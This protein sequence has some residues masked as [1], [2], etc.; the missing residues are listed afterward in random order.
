MEEQGARCPNCQ[1]VF[2]V[3]ASQLNAAGGMVRCGICLETFDALSNRIDIEQQASPKSPVWAHI[4]DNDQVI[5]DRFD[6]SLLEEDDLDLSVLESEETAQGDPLESSKIESNDAYPPLPETRTVQ[7]ESK[8]L[9]EFQP[10]EPEP[11]FDWEASPEP[12]TDPDSASVDYRAAAYQEMEATNKAI[13][14]LEQTIFGADSPRENDSGTL[15]TEAGPA[16]TGP[17]SPESPEPEDAYQNNLLQRT[18]DATASPDAAETSLAQLDFELSSALPETIAPSASLEELLAANQNP[19][20]SVAMRSITSSFAVLLLGMGI[21][22]T[23]WFFFQADRLGSEADYASLYRAL[24][25]GLPCQSHEFRDIS[26]IQTKNLVVRTHPHFGSALRVDATLVNLAE[27]PQPFPRMVL[28]FEDLQGAVLARRSFKPEE[29]L[30]GELEGVGI[31]PSRQAI[32]F[33]LD[34][35]DPGEQAVSYTLI[36]AH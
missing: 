25:R 1:L 26:A 19:K 5:D 9:S 13:E 14:Q 7:P 36:P 29:Y 8:P 3:A 27:R 20:R 32:H 18:S 34:V 10:P 31:M 30:K 12:P 2:R 11:E 17:A 35:I 21:L 15:A 6:P 22:A 33:I 4:D 28:T 24:C 16:A 23:Q